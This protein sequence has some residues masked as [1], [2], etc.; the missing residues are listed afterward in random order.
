M[1]EKIQDLEGNQTSRS[2]TGDKDDK[3]II[4]RVSFGCMDDPDEFIVTKD[5]KYSFVSSKNLKDDKTAYEVIYPDYRYHLVKVN[6]KYHKQALQAKENILNETG[7]KDWPTYDFGKVAGRQP[8]LYRKTLWLLSHNNLDGWEE[9]FTPLDAELTCCTAQ[10]RNYCDMLYGDDH[11]HEYRDDK[12]EAEEFLCKMKRLIAD[13]WSGEVST[14][15]FE[16]IFN[17]ERKQVLFVNLPRENQNMVMYIDMAGCVRRVECV[18]EQAKLTEKITERL[19]KDKKFKRHKEYF[20]RANGDEIVNVLFHYAYELDA[21]KTYS[22]NRDL[23][24]KIYQYIA[25]RWD[26][27]DAYYNLGLF[28]Q[29][30][31]GSLKKDIKTAI[32]YYE[33]AIKKGDRRYAAN[34]LGN[35]YA[36]GNGVPK[37]K[38]RAMRYFQIAADNGDVYAVA[39]LAK[40]YEEGKVVERNQLRAWKLYNE[41]RDDSRWDKDI[42]WDFKEKLE[43]DIKRLEKK[44]K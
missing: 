19:S 39:S 23:A 18:G 1:G 34:N 22:Q 6:Q 36:T 26:E 24:Y 11:I 35:I 37:D 42:S 32:K 13:D 2:K 7:E 33:L 14:D 27:A 25:E 8:E 5:G 15:E 41:A 43:K 16:Q 9:S 20:D 29:E 30:G 28:H 3:E 17:Q 12:A 21:G 10:Y 44:L 4:F 38:K 31:Y 40:I